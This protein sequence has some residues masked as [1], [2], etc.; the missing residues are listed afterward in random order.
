MMMLERFKGAQVYI[1]VAAVPLR[2]V[3][4]TKKNIYHKPRHGAK[5]AGVFSGH[6][7]QRVLLN[8]RS[9]KLESHLIQGE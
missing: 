3:K 9:L 2:Q 5:A 8:L 7:K 1:E 4:V 6:Y